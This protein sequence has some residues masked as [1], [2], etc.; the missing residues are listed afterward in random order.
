MVLLREVAGRLQAKVKQTTQAINRLHNLLA[1]VFPE[2]ATLTDDIAAGWVLRAARQ[3]SHRRTHR[4]GPPRLPGEDPPSLRA[5]R[6]RRCTRPPSS[7]WRRSAAT[8]AEALVRELVAQVRHCQQAEQHLRQLLIAAFADLPASPHVQVLTIPGI[9]EATAAAL[10]AKIVDIDRFATPDH[11][12]GYF[13]VFP[14][15]NS[16]G[17][18]KQGKP[19]PPGTLGMSPQGQRPGPRLPLERRSQRHP[20]QPRHPRPLSPAQGQGQTRRRRDRPL[21]AQAAPPRLRRLED[22]SPLRRTPFS[23]EHC[24]TPMSQGPIC[25]TPMSSGLDGDI[26]MSA[27]LP[28]G[29]TTDSSNDRSR[30]PQTGRARRTS[31]HH[32]FR[33]SKIR[34]RRLSSRDPASI[35]LSCAARFSMQQVLQHWASWSTCAAAAP[36]AADRAPC[37]ATTTP[38]NQ[39]SVHLGNNVFHCFDANCTA[40][41]NVLDLWAAV[42]RLPIYEA[43]LHLAATFNLAVNR[44]EEP[45]NH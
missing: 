35:S 8:S 21:H 36:N 11:L 40:H 41:G 38:T 20:P 39:L 30:G 24:D 27:G 45:V 3:V 4:R 10:V 9:G 6:P 32:G 31:G 14:E 12:V 44:E 5:S 13:G 26:A 42:H 16:S 7:P 2:L 17:V 18:D 15:E 29:R 33:Y 37:L 34:T 22:R 19:L 43:A 25:D 28:R 1:R 23:W